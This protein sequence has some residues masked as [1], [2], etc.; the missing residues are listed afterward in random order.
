MWRRIDNIP[1]TVIAGCTFYI[2]VDVFS[3]GVDCALS[4][5]IYDSEKRDN[6]C[7]RQYWGRYVEFSNFKVVRNKIFIEIQR[8][9]GRAW[10]DMP[11]IAQRLP[12]IPQQRERLLGE[13]R[14]RGL[15]GE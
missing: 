13:L 9:L 2:S 6:A 10:R 15:F 8:E 5:S 3:E 4:V 1:D 12:E 14:K 11:Q 7:N